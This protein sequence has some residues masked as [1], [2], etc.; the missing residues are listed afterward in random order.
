MALSI[1]VTFIHPIFLDLVSSLKLPTFTKLHALPQN[2]IPF[3]F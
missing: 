3:I 1:S 2:K